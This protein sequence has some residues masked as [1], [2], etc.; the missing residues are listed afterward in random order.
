M[1]YGVLYS[2]KFSQVTVQNLKHII[3]AEDIDRLAALQLVDKT[4]TDWS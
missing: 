1:Y 4:L 3:L 2:K